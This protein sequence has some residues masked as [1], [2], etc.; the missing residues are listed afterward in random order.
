MVKRSLV[1]PIGRDEL[2]EL[3]TRPEQLSGWFGAEVMK[4][5]LRLA[6]T[7]VVRTE[8]GQLRRGV[9]ETLDPPVRFGFRWLPVAEN[10]DDATGEFAES[11]VEFLLEETAEG[12]RLTVTEWSDSMANEPEPDES[13]SVRLPPPAAES[14]P[15]PPGAPPRIF[16]HA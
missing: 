16:M 2:W 8:S 7:I 1:L 10:P 6:G 4:I 5:D 14:P 3:L 9:I 15:D 11:S 12:T 13:P